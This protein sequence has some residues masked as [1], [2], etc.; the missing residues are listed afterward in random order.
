MS[1]I[2]IIGSPRSGTTI[3]RLMLSAHENIMIA[4]ECGFIQWWHP[5]YKNW[6]SD[7]FAGK[8]SEF[9]DDL[10]NSKRFE[11]WKLQKEQVHKRILK[12][13][14]ENYSELVSLIY[15]MY[16]E[17]HG[18]EDF[19]WGDKNNYYLNHI[20]LLQSLFP[21]AFFIHL[22]RD[23]RDI[24]C[25]YKRIH[26]LKTR[27]SPNLPY[28]VNEICLEWNQ[29]ISKI[30]NGFRKIPETNKLKIKYESL[31][32][33]QEG[34]LSSILKTLNLPLDKNMLDYH[35]INKKLNLDPE[36][37]KSW[38]E[39]SFK[40]IIKGKVGTYRRELDNSEIA[41]IEKITNQHL[42]LND[43]INE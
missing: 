14:P 6:N 4:P 40:P 41:I 10:F 25:S 37:Y 5:K 23:S 12:D 36:A 21:R 26:N 34:T 16:G 15:K 8:I 32:L 18:K 39:N 31:V 43:Y 20:G 9:V 42:I 38:K 19:I 7:F 30:E 17:L 24:V 29:N 35:L 11:F 33:D 13:K 27:L 3:L 2:F 28:N 1:P 22:I